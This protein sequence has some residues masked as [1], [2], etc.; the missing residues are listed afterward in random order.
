[1]IWVYILIVFLLLLIE[2]LFVASEMAL[3]TLREGKVKSLA[4]RGRRGRRVQRLVQNPNRFLSAVQ[5][6]VTLAA[7]GSSAFGEVT[8]AR[9]ATDRLR[10]AGVSHW[11]AGTIGFVG[12]FLVIT[13]ATLVI[14]ELEPK[15]L[16][17]QRARPSSG[18]ASASARAAP[19]ASCAAPGTRRR[20]AS[21]Q[22]RRGWPGEPRSRLSRP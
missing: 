4:E 9:S 22:P 6:G 11:A 7:L 13:Y 21:G 3:V 14:G 1:M 19:S 2:A 10:E 8:L 12:V 16:A 20:E 5:I 17:L 18:A 15:R